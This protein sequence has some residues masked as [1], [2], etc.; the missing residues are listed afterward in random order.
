VLASDLN[1]PNFVNATNPDNLLHV[2]F[3]WHEPVDK[4]A[5]ETTGKI[6]KGPKTPFIRIVKPGDNTSILETPVREDHKARFP[7]KWMY[8]QM[9]EGLVEN[10]D[11]PGWK[12]EEWNEIDDELRRE[13]KFLRFSVVEQIAGA[14]DGQVQKMGMGG[15]GLREKAKRALQSRMGAET[16]DAIQQKDKEI[17]DLKTKLDR[18]EGLIQAKLAAPEPTSPE[19]PSEAPVAAPRK[20][21][22]KGSKNKPKV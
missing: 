11:I 6:T 19:P 8:F 20:G 21:R 13:L 17:Q 14:S 12:L 4:W 9:K 7:D 18:L 15:M 16:R 10:Q 1:N 5:T 3:Y 2:E 22:P